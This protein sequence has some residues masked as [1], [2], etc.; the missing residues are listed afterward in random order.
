VYDNF[1]DAVVSTLQFRDRLEN[2]KSKNDKVSGGMQKAVEIRTGE[3]RI[4]ETKEGRS[5]G[6]G[7][8]KTGRKRK[9][10]EAEKRKDGESKES[11]RGVGDLG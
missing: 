2:G 6:G 7:R 10:E 3:V 11:S 9:E 8:K 4:G 5:K 1:G